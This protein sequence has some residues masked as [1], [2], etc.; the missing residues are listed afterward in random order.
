MARSDLLLDLIEA[1]QR[2]DKS[3]FR[4]LVETIIAEERANQH[5]LLADRLAELI[6]THG[7]SGTPQRDSYSSAVSD[8]VHEVIPRKRIDDLRL[9]PLVQQSVRELIEEHHRGDLLRSYGIEPRNRVLFEGPPGNGKTS[10]AEALATELMLPFYTVR[11]EGVVSSFLG[12]TTARLDQVFDFAR[13]R[14]CVLFFDELDTLAKERADAHETGEIK[15][16]VSTLLMQIDRLPAHVILV[17]ATNHSEL[18]DRAAW[19]RFQ[20]RIT[21]ESPSRTNMTAYLEGLVKQLGGHLGF[22]PR[23][24]AD[25]LAGASY[26]EVEEFAKDI[27]RRVILTGPGADTPTIVRE[28]IAMWRSQASS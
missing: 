14:R 2:G 15:R 21:L 3:R 18:L 1:E 9:A 10:L 13:T 11:Y 6:T 7:H 24:L 12:E 23:T 5:H 19:R 16:V 20:L 26:A 17:G 8:L 4:G 22:T 27:R 25:K 28:R